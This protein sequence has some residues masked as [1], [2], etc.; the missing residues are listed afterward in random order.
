MI[1]DVLA[2]LQG[3]Y[4][5]ENFYI[6]GDYISF[7]DSTGGTSSFTYTNSTVDDDTF[8]NNVKEY[9]TSSGF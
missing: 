9:M 7:N 1:Q 2:T 6:D 5:S 4:P 8:V 3:L